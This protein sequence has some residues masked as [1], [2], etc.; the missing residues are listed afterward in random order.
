MS[1][2]IRTPNEGDFFAWLGLYE[3]YAEIYQVALTDEKALRLWTWLTDVAHAEH[4]LVAVDDNGDLL[5]LVHFHTFPRPLEST[6][7][8]FI[9]DVFVLPDARHQGVGRAL[10]DTVFETAK[11]QRCDT[12]RWANAPEDS[13]ARALYDDLGAPSELVMYE[14]QLVPAE[15]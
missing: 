3:G 10:I 11:Q 13:D 15:A 7:G 14:R 4:G 12:V 2:S 1:I 8:V 6:N 5:G 9:D